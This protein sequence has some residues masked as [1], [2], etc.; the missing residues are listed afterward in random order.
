MN[1]VPALPA[2]LTIHGVA[3]AARAWQPWLDAAPDTERLTVDA[4]APADVDGAGVQLLIALSNA[5]QQRGRALDLLS[6]SAA[7]IEA[8]T[9]LGAGFLLAAAHETE[10][11][12]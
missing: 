9:R 12:R 4:S 8:C 5:L 3:D 6:P 7:L 2:E 10:S 11:A 1:T